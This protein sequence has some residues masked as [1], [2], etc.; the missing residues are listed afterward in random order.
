M[1]T[2]VKKVCKGDSENSSTATYKNKIVNYHSLDFDK[3]SKLICFYYLGTYDY[4]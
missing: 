2:Y 4:Q 3:Y 1:S